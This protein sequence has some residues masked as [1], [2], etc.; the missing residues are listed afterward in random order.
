MRPVVGIRLQL[1]SLDLV[2]GRMAGRLDDGT[3]IVFGIED[4]ETP[5]SRSSGSDKHERAIH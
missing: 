3:M 2:M 5:D 4:C 1:T